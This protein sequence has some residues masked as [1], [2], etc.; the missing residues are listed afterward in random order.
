MATKTLADI[1]KLITYTPGV[2]G[3]HPCLSGTRIPMRTL[4]ARLRM[5]E[6]PED[7]AADRL[8]F[9]ANKG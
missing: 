3:G 8:E 6:T 5:G 4:A 7:L 2:V 9:L 1:G